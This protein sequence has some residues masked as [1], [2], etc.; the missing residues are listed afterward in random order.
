MMSERKRPDTVVAA[1]SA[2]VDFSLS[3]SSWLVYRC[4]APN[5]NCCHRAAE[6]AAP[7]ARGG[8][9]AG[10]RGCSVPLASCSSTTCA[11]VGVQPSARCL[12]R[13]CRSTDALVFVMRVRSA[14]DCGS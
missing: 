9:T 14:V 2:A 6:V 5:W 13:S 7:A 8:G 12:P 10:G 4:V 1:S 3:S 11:S